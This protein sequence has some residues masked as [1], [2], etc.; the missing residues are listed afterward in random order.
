MSELGEIN[1]HLGLWQSET[2]VS[3][4]EREWLRYVRRAEK[5]LGHSIDGNEA[6]DGYSLDRCNDYFT[7]CDEVEI[8]VADVIAAKAELDAAFGPVLA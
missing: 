2:F 8:Y 4:N 3:D 7:N 5:L 6:T 1:P